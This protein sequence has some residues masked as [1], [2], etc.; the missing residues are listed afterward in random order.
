MRLS[1]PHPSG[2]RKAAENVALARPPAAGIRH[3]EG[4]VRSMAERRPA[5]MTGS[6]GWLNRQN[7]FHQ[8]VTA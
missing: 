4:R 6:E 7:A 3:G 8:E 2:T 5:A 1:T